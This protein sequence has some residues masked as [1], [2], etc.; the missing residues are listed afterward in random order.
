MV[1]VGWSPE[2]IAVDVNPLVH[3]NVR[4]QGSFSHNYA[5][6][7]RDP[8]AGQ[9]PHDARHDRWLRAPLAGWS[10]AF[11]AMHDRRVIVRSPSHGRV[12]W[13]R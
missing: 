7:A 2:V 9:G 3:R 10:E 1:K 8:L 6:G 12:N 5:M 4:L 13:P 11:D